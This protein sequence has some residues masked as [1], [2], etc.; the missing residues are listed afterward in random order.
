MGL[1]AELVDDPAR[2]QA[3]R[4]AWDA[5]AVDLGR[6]YCAPAW[7]LAWWEHARPSGALL[8]TVLVRDGGELVA[9]A[10]FYAD[11]RLARPVYYRLLASDISHRVAPLIRRGD[12]GPATE[13]IAGALA[14][15]RPRPAVI[16]FESVESQSRW[17]ERFVDGWPGAARPWAV[18]E[19]RGPA[20]TVGLE[21][22]NFD[23]WMQA[24]SRNFRSQ[25]G[26]MR[27]HL[28]AKGARFRLAATPD[29]AQRALEALAELH[30]ARWEARGGSMALDPGVERMLG[31]A[32]SELLAEGRFR[33][34]SIEAGGATISAHLFVAAGGQVA[35]W[36][37][38]FDAA[39]AGDQ[40]SMRV[41][42]EAIEDAMGRSDRSLDLG[43]GSEE[44]K[45]RLADGEDLLETCL[46]VPR[47]PGY[48]FTRAQL[49]P[50]R[51]R[52]HI[53]SK[54]PDR[55]G[56]RLRRSRKRR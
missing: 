25:A 29:Q 37:G 34:F 55:L 42:V 5:L 17:P 1:V 27:R 35:Y 2:L 23:R 26:R 18:R 20:P 36:N 48:R 28:E 8:R 10:P 9:V 24:K 15:A 41:L 52:R 30:Y 7:L 4:A 56:A 47:G 44:Y 6:P 21:G 46:V 3:T 16:R 39:F 12:E 43:G 14:A 19:W 22:Q 50:R 53:G 11:R 54:L 51:L 49:A 31:Q 13:A 38:G 33:L 45:R 32:A 40:P